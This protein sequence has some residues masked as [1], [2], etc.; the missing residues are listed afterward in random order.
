MKITLNHR[1]DV[2]D[3]SKESITINELLKLKKFSF[4][5]LVVKIN[6]TLIKREN[7]DSASFKENDNVEIIHMIS[8]G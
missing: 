3:T 6:G 1:D 4:T 2:L 7:F 5:R 8:G